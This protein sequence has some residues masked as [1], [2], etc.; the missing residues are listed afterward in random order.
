MRREKVFKAENFI[1]NL[2]EILAKLRLFIEVNLNEHLERNRERME[3]T[4]GG[5]G[6]KEINNEG[7]SVI[8]CAVLSRFAAVNT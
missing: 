4:D 8:D 3:R 2:R 6:V 7:E 5:C 1:K